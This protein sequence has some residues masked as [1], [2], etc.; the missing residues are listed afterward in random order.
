MTDIT[1]SG[2]DVCDAQSFSAAFRKSITT[3]DDAPAPQGMSPFV[4]GTETRRDIAVVPY[5]PSWPERFDR[6]RA[7]IVEALGFRVLS[8]EHI[9]STSV[10]GLAAKPVIDIDLTVADSDKEGSYVP[11]LERSGFRLVIREPW[12]Y[13]HRM[14]RGDNPACNLHVWSLGSPEAI[15]H[16]LFRNWLR[17]NEADRDWY[18]ETKCKAAE[19]TAKTG[20]LPSDYNRRK[21]ETIRKIY[22]RVFE[23]AGLVDTSNN[24]SDGSDVAEG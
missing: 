9:G 8:I 22:K 5:D 2:I 21:Q 7:T 3:F 10:S 14:F 6:L 1:N 18:G 20:E 12:W 24:R 16:L 13:G 19:Y 15:R 4:S 23:A 11:A 17:M